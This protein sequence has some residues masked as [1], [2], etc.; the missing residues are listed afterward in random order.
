MI[1]IPRNNQCNMSLHSPKDVSVWPGSPVVLTMHINMKSNPEFHEMQKSFKAGT[2]VLAAWKYSLSC[3]NNGTCLQMSM[4]KSNQCC[5]ISAS[6]PCFIKFPRIKQICEF[7]R[8]NTMNVHHI[9]IQ[10]TYFKL[11]DMVHQPIVKNRKWNTYFHFTAP[12]INII[13][14]AD[15]VDAQIIRP[16]FIC[17]NCVEYFFIDN[18]SHKL[19]V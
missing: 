12:S 15:P 2:F 1:Q 3:L 10:H 18:K 16:I 19:H 9:I 5:R 6:N 4:K 7:L 8:W 17:T 14:R 13:S 11:L